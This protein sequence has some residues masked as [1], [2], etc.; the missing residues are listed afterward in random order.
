MSINFVPLSREEFWGENREM[1]RLTAG[2]QTRVEEA[3][4]EGFVKFGLSHPWDTTSRQNVP[5][6]YVC[7]FGSHPVPCDVAHQ[8]LSAR[9]LFLH[10]DE[11]FD[12]TKP[13]R[14]LIILEDV[15]PRMA[16]MLG[17]KL[18]IP[19][20]LISFW[21]MTHVVI[22]MDPRQTTL[23]KLKKGQETDR[24]S[25]SDVGY[26]RMY[27]T[28]EV[29]VGAN[30][31]S[32]VAPHARM[33]YENLRWAYDRN[34]GI[35][36]ELRDPFVATVPVRNLVLSLW[37][38]SACRNQ[39]TLYDELWRDEAQW[40][41][42]SSTAAVKRL[43]STF[44]TNGKAYQ[45]IMNKG[46]TICKQRLLIKHIKDCFLAPDVDQWGEDSGST[47]L[48]FGSVKDSTEGVAV[49]QMRWN[50]VDDRLQEVEGTL[51]TWADMQRSFVNNRQARNAGQLTKLATVAVP[52]S[53][54]SAIFSMGGDF[55]AGERLFWVYW[56]VSLPVT[57]LLLVWIISS[58]EISEYR[59]RF[60]GYLRKAW[61]T[62]T[63]G[64][65]HCKNCTCNKGSDEEV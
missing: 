50:K 62:R 22:L 39:S 24:I 34:F 63:K 60:E 56:G 35:I 4:A 65:H 55:A 51:R 32:S 49:E 3:V 5:R 16:E 52:F 18:D 11:A 40:R 9:D 61:P 26:D 59:H 64:R 28:R 48:T 36:S 33:M 15:D 45:N 1:I 17:V 19:P 10:F 29:I 54:I 8:E 58:G 2:Y 6:F 20:D 37:E 30:D 43:E 38:D 21:G 46:P 12:A 53:I 7:N 42:F 27:F 31:A 57:G 23:R 25:L 41:D 13:F 44:D 47:A 14:R